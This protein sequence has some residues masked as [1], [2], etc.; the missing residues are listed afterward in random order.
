MPNARTTSVVR[1][2][3][4]DDDL[5][6]VTWIE[7]RVARR[8][9]GRGILLA[10]LSSTTLIGAGHFGSLSGEY[11]VWSMKAYEVSL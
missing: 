4:G 5:D 9:L 6:S 7:L 11:G 3:P 8:D 10:A 1:E 2:D